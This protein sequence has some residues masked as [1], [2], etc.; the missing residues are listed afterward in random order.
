MLERDEARL[1]EA[2]NWANK[3]QMADATRTFVFSSKDSACKAAKTLVKAGV[4]AECQ[5]LAVK[6]TRPHDTDTARRFWKIL[7]LNRRR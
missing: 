6:I 2:F 3:R 7:S 5:C 1:Q 4:R